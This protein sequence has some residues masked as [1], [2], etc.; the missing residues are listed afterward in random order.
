MCFPF[1]TTVYVYVNGTELSCESTQRNRN[2]YKENAVFI[3]LLPTVNISGRL[4]CF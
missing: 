1:H 4:N 3:I 2:R